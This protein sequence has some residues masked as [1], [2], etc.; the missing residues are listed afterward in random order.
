VHIVFSTK[1][2]RPFLTDQ[3]IRDEMHRVL[4]GICN[5]LASPALTVG[6][7]MDHVHILCRLGKTC[8]PAELIKE[9]KRESSLWVKTRGREFV[10][11]HWQAGYGAF[12][13]S[14]GHVEALRQYIAN[15]EKHHR[16]ETFQ[17]EF[18]RL[19]RKYGV[20]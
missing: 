13:V 8:S 19:L 9:L 5:D 2:R 16:T 12:S 10:D 17:E 14:P 15:Q 11:F 6:G 4:G 3:A 1:D 20:E 7:I 18:R